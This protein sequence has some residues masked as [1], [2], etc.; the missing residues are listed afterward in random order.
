MRDDRAPKSKRTELS[1]PRSAVEP[2]RDPHSRSL[3]PKRDP[4]SRSLEPKRDPHS[5]SLEPVS[6]AR[7]LPDLLHPVPFARVDLAKLERALDFAF[8]SG[9]SH[10]EIQD[11]LERAARVPSAWEPECFERD[12]FLSDLVQQCFPIVIDGTSLSPGREHFTALV[13]HPPADREVVRYRQEI[14]AELVARPELRADL[15][16]V[17]RGVRRFKELLGPLDRHEIPEINRR[18]IETL[19]VAREVIEAMAAGFE[20]AR[21]GLGRLRRFGAALRESEAFARL[22]SFLELEGHLAGLEVRL[23]VG[24]DGSLR[25]FDI[26]KLEENRHNPFYESPLKR[27][28]RK[29][30]QL[31]R[32]YKFSD[33]EVFEALIDGVFGPLRGELV[34]LF[35]LEGDLELYLAA[36][37]FR[38]LARQRGLEV[39]IPE[40]VAHGAPQERSLTGLFNP[41]LLSEPR[42]PVPC[43]LGPARHDAIAV[44][45]GPN[46][47]GKTRV[48]Q[49][50][51]IAQMLGQ[52]GLFVP[53][54]SARLVWADGMFVSLVQEAR[55]DQKEGRLGMELCRIRDV[56]E[57]LR[58]GGVVMLDELCSGTNPS[59]GEEIFELV[60]TLL[61]ELEPQ[62]FITT[63]F[64]DF[65]ARLSAKDTSGRLAFLQVELDA[66]DEPTYQFVPGVAETSLASKTAAR[67]G[68]TREDLRRL[69]DRGKRAAA[70]PAAEPDGAA[71]EP[72]ARRA[73]GGVRP[74]PFD[75]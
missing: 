2:K 39:S 25:S 11:C 63:H 8:A 26:V 46:S 15:E 70:P 31:V 40:I 57:R 61:A 62:A 65:A 21:S 3:E 24:H 41:L 6:V 10:T 49:A 12:V 55:A 37:G 36:L 20:G 44:I 5:R 54:E 58:P 75:A 45:T 17:Y 59:E 47:G 42:A 48:L 50:V 53:A 69:I 13:A 16:R 60:T 33:D 19:G 7:D 66:D 51:A 18:R 29:L 23:R 34:K 68:V 32:G 71:T 9:G 35:Q 67:L 74:E 73:G 38:D 22:A 4:H 30:M 52:A 14:L 72:P 64:L 43:S 28:W 1:A 27:L 56:F